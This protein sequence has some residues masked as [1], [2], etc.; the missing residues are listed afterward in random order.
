MTPFF[1]SF[2]LLVSI[3]LI[4]WFASPAFFWPGCFSPALRGS[5]SAYP[6]RTPTFLV[7]PRSLGPWEYIPFVF[8]VGRLF[9]W[10]VNGG[11]DPPPQKYLAFFP[12]LSKPFSVRVFWSLFPVF[13][14]ENFKSFRLWGMVHA[15][16]SKGRWAPSGRSVKPSAEVMAPPTWFSPNPFYISH[17]PF[18]PTPSTFK[19]LC[20]S[21]FFL[22]S[23]REP[24]VFATGV[25]FFC[26]PPFFPSTS[27]LGPDCGCSHHVTSPLPA[28]LIFDAR[29]LD[30]G[31]KLVNSSS[32]LGL[33]PCSF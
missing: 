12:D 7:L 22:I 32:V 8:A 27:A 23:S 11:L 9:S 29:P 15:P 16:F 25:S 18:E 13:L 14:F 33:G 26:A 31:L 21:L 17:T 20:R 19:C 4:I 24:V 1:R 30:L 5:S 3:P 6:L 2:Q 28:R 10:R